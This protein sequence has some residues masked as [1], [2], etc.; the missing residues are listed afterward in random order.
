MVDPI[1]GAALVLGGVKAGAELLGL[2]PTSRAIDRE[3]RYFKKQE[4]RRRQFVNSLDV[5]GLLKD[6]E[7]G[8]RELP[9]KFRQ[10]TQTALTSKTQE[11][12]A[13]LTQALA[14]AGVTGASE[15]AMRGRRGVLAGAENA[16]Q[17]ADLKASELEQSLQK[18]ELAA[19]MNVTNLLYPSPGQTAAGGAAAAGQYV[20]PLGGLSNILLMSALAGGSGGWKD[21]IPNPTPYT[22]GTYRGSY[23][24]VI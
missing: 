15:I 16:R 6:I 10:R 24:R 17:T 21:T 13:R 9:R 18:G 4:R 14:N 7:S 12:M 1:F 8:T 3:K 22:G 19:K 5:M 23:G 11:E 20:D 2:D